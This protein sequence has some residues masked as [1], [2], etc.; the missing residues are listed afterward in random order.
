[1]GQ[2]AVSFFSF[3]Q[4]FGGQNEADLTKNLEIGKLMTNP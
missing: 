3:A 1:M 4:G 2:V